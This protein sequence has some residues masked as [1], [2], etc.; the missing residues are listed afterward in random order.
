MCVEVGAD[1]KQ[2]SVRDPIGTQGG[3]GDGGARVAFD[4]V[5]GPDASQRE[6]FDAAGGHLVD[7]VFGGYNCAVVAFG[8]TGSG[9]THT[10]LGD[11][12]LTATS[13]TSF[14]SSAN[15]GIIPRTIAQLYER[16]ARATERGAGVYTYSL[17]ASYV[18]LY[19]GVWTDLLRDVVAMV[20]DRGRNG[21][22]AAAA[23]RAAAAP[24]LQIRKDSARG[25]FLNGA[26]EVCSTSAAALTSLV[27]MAEMNRRVSATLM[28]ERSSRSHAVFTLRLARTETR[29]NATRVSK[30]VLVDLAG[31]ENIRTT[32][33]AGGALRE[34]SQ[35]NLSLTALG[36]VIAALNARG[37]PHVPYRDSPLTRLLSDVVGGNCRTSLM[38]TCTSSSLSYSETMCTVRFGERARWKGKTQTNDEVR[39]PPGSAAG[40]AAGLAARHRG[41]Q[42]GAAHTLSE[43][44]MGELRAIE[45]RGAAKRAGLERR[46]ASTGSAASPPPSPAAR[47]E[48]AQRSAGRGAEAFRRGSSPPSLSTGDPGATREGLLRQ[49]AACESSALRCG[50][51]LRTADDQRVA[52]IAQG[53]LSR[54]GVQAVALASKLGVEERIAELCRTLALLG[55]DPALLQSFGF[56]AKPAAEAMRDAREAQTEADAGAAAKA[57]AAAEEEKEDAA[58]RQQAEI[59]AAFAAEERRMM[60]VRALAAS[61]LDSAKTQEAMLF[62]RIDE[63]E[64]RLRGVRDERCVLKEQHI[65]AAQ[66]VLVEARNRHAKLSARLA[67]LH[68]QTN[69][70]RD[71]LA[72]QR[73]ASETAS[74]ALQDARA[75]N[76]EL[77]A[78]ARQAL[79]EQRAS[80]VQLE[81]SQQGLLSS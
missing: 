16:M 8:Q 24:V 55:V 1:G 68:A 17:Y 29:T 14:A 70:E 12:S 67:G 25:V 75:Q 10:M 71:A 11:M 40:L 65:P 54:V 9:K 39:P 4:A 27:R 60:K 74:R 62:D 72:A 38:L 21:G 69:R 66:A 58:A 48:Q 37:R 20:G 33:A 7:D 18:E 36:R 5:F 47:W 43:H 63:L 53:Q 19:S 56:S 49:L 45:E 34:A 46:V 23:R 61:M 2:A 57:A 6:V 15:A 28:N 51:E 64:A 41:A 26:T 35:I 79:V 13:A 52:A 44:E 76:R 31:S 78:Y 32:N 22:A 42:R 73:D 77:E 59:D 81:E 3:K 80:Y 50:H 30:C